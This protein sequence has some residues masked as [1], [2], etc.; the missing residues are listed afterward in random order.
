MAETNCDV[1]LTDQTLTFVNIDNMTM[2]SK[3]FKIQAIDHD[4][5]YACL[6]S[7]PSATFINNVYSTCLS[8]SRLSFPPVNNFVT[9]V[10]DYVP[11]IPEEETST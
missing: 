10:V 6:D 2:T 4:K 7:D 1:C 8:P 5:I 3:K 9:S 11:P